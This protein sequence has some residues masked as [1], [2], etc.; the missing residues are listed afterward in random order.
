MIFQHRER[1]NNELS[2][3]PMV[4]QCKTKFVEEKIKRLCK[5]GQFEDIGR[6]QN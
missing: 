2:Y 5:E 1:R 3:F 6:Y 4:D